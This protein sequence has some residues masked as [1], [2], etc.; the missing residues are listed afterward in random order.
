MSLTNFELI[1]LAHKYNINLIDVFSKDQL[2]YRRKPGGYIINLQDEM[3]AENEYNNG[4]HWC[5]FYIKG[6]QACYFDSFGIICPRQVQEF[7]KGLTLVYNTKDI[8]NI[9]SEVCG[10]YCLFFLFWFERQ[11]KINSFADRLNIFCNLFSDDSR[12][13]ES[14][15]KKYFSKFKIK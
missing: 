2:P 11:N 12:K 6:N 8:Q 5:A 3:N 1:D 9:T 14:L 13:N 15:L 10:W 4:T 7:C